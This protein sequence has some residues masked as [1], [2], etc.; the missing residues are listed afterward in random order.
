MA[1]TTIVK[2][3]WADLGD[4]VQNIIYMG[5]APF[6]TSV[7]DDN[8]EIQKFTYTLETDSKYYVSQIQTLSGKNWTDRATYPWA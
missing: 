7:N 6:G 5:K 3:E 4:A 8:W 1:E 2:F